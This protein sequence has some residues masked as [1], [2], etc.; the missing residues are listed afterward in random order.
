MSET[1]QDYRVQAIE[2]SVEDIHA[3]LKDIK[4]K[5]DDLDNTMKNAWGK[6]TTSIDVLSSVINERDKQSHMMHEDY[7]ATFERFGTK[8]DNMDL[9]LRSNELSLAQTD[10]VKLSERV[11]KIELSNSGK[12]GAKKVHLAMYSVIGAVAM[13]FLQIVVPF[14][15]SKLV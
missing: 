4:F 2:G 11:Y 1:A 9:R 14:L 8:I 10:I 12:E 7:K 5:F 15:L 3:D 13:L 6:L